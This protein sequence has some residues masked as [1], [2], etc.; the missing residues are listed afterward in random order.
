MADAEG[1]GGAIASADVEGLA[2]AGVS[3]LAVALAAG[4]FFS[5]DV[6]D[7]TGE[8]DADG[9]NDVSGSG[10]GNADGA[11]AG[12][13][14]AAVDAAEGTCVTVAGGGGGSFWQAVERSRGRAKTRR[15]CI[16]SEV[17]PERAGRDGVSM[18]RKR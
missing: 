17:L 9:A 11:A 2:E 14:A 10:C 12:A 4:F 16:L 7:A 1:F 8:A 6:A 13:L 3:G 15:M 5:T 18:R